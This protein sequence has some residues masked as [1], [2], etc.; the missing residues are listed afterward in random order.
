M[1]ANDMKVE[2]QTSDM[3]SQK[4]DAK[5]AD[6]VAKKDPDTKDDKEAKAVV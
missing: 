4:I 5:P 6:M 1:T 3:S 2:D